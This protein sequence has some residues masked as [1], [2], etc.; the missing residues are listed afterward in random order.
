[1]NRKYFRLSTIVDKS[2]G[3]APQLE[4]EIVPFNDEYL[5]PM[6]V[7]IDAHYIIIQTFYFRYTNAIEALREAKNKWQTGEFNNFLDELIAEIAGFKTADN[8]MEVEP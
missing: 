7:I 5:P 4:T 8:Q 1:M 2:H 3:Q 6:H